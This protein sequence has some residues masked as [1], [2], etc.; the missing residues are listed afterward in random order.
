VKAGIYFAAA[1]V[2]LIVIAWLLLRLGYD[3]PAEQRAIGTSAAVALLVQIA[4]FAI[5]RRASPRSV[6]VGWGLGA[7][8]RLAVLVTYALLAVPPLALPR[9]AALVSLATFLFVSMLVEPLLLAY[10]R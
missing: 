5:A 10:D 6:I 8:L 7:M 3:S 1:T 2:G 4:T 9:S